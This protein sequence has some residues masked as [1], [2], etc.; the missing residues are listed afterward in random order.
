MKKIFWPNSIFCNFKNGQ[1]WAFELGKKFK[2]SKNA[3]S[4]NYFFDLFDF[5]SFFC[6]EFFKF[7]GPLFGIEPTV[8]FP[9]SSRICKIS[10]P[11][12]LDLETTSDEIVHSAESSSSE[13]LSTKKGI[14][15]WDFYIVIRVG[16][17]VQSFLF[18]QENGFWFNWCT[19]F[20]GQGKVRLAQNSRISRFFIFIND[21]KTKIST[22][23]KGDKSDFQTHQRDDTIRISVWAQTIDL[24][25]DRQCGRCGS[26]KFYI[27]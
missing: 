11:R 27:R 22:K 6:L 8:L 15:H 7:S 16:Q 5:T 10:N 26:S 24:H 2:T 17:T 14:M 13:P 18:S 20:L 21:F 23:S 12:T 19:R 9:A 25:L 3:I 1:K 4:R